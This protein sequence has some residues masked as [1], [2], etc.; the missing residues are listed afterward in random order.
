MAVY[1][2]PSNAA[3]P[4]WA[5][6]ITNIANTKPQKFWADL[7]D[8]RN[9]VLTNTYEEWMM[10]E[11][12]SDYYLFNDGSDCCDLWFPASNNC[13]DTQ[14]SVTQVI[15]EDDPYQ[16]YFFPDFDLNSCAHGRDYPAWMG[17]EGYTRWYLFIDPQECCSKYFPASQRCPY[18]INPQS[19]YYWESNNSD[20][21]NGAADTRPYYN[22]TYYPNMQLGTCINGTDY[23]SW[24]IETEE[25]KRLYIFNE[26]Q[27][28][29]EFWFGDFG[30]SSG[31]V[32]NVVQGDYDASITVSTNRTAD[33][34]EK[35]YPLLEQRRCVKDGATPTWMLSETF[36]DY[37]TFSSQEACCAMFC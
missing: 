27:G 21:A 15:E 32:S 9:C 36:S 22:H 23:P 13:P 30:E 33:L 8:N 14:A 35:W 1:G 11:G 2:H 17:Q 3:Y 19:G 26:P 37:Y 31:C 4:P 5:P 12:F 34:L 24:M 7:V 18:E 25:F 6:A 29:C 10:E 20:N 16:N 28:C